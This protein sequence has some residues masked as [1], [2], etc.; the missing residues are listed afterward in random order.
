MSA[1]P[2]GYAWRDVEDDVHRIAV[3]KGWWEGG[4]R[5]D[6]ELCALVHSE[7]SEMLEALRHGN[8]PDD[9][10]PEFSGAEAEA[11]DVVIRL[12]D[13]AVHRGWDIAGAI[14]AKVEYNK[15]RERRHG[16]AF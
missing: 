11:A 9:K 5:N 16:K 12:M 13:W 1:D 7:L 6:G 2:F 15:T 10:I 3:E 4:D 14:Q 8:G